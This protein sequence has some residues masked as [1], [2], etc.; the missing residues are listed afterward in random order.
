METLSKVLES[1]MRVILNSAQYV[2]ESTLW[3]LKSKIEANLRSLKAL[4]ICPLKNS[5]TRQ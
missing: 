3:K 5:I 2:F 1:D 4:V